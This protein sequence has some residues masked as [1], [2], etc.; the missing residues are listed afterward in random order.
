MP[1]EGF[2]RKD[3]RAQRNAEIKVL[4][5]VFASCGKFHMLPI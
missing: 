1:E 4:C 2:S 3:A 5:A